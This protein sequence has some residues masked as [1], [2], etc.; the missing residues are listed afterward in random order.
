MTTEPV[1]AMSV[2]GAAVNVTVPLPLPLPLFP[3][4]TD[5]QAELL[6]ACHE[7]PFGAATDTVKLPP[8]AGTCPLDSARFTRQGAAA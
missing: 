2:L 8:V 3:A 7:H 1:R 4:V 5:S 6:T